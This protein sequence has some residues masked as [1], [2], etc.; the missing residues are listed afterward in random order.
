MQF[1][2]SR[3]DVSERKGDGT[4]QTNTWCESD[5]K[6]DTFWGKWSGHRVTHLGVEKPPEKSQV[7]AGHHYWLGQH[8]L[9]IWQIYWWMEQLLSIS[10]K[11]QHLQ[12]SSQSHTQDKHS[13]IHKTCTKSHVYTHTPTCMYAFTLQHILFCL[14]DHLHNWFN[15]DILR[16]DFPAST[17]TKCDVNMSQLA[18]FKCH[19]GS[20]L[21]CT[22]IKHSK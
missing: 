20:Q 22:L 6:K 14:S 9:S 15:T 18:F 19:R 2:T 12:C 4:H 3:G 21:K 11:L 1:Q 16:K 13:I 10:T 5:L 17:C 7:G 8:F